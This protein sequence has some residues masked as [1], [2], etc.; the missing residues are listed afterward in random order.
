M[1]Q[2]PWRIA[3]PGRH[4][5]WRLQE[6]R[7]H[8]YSMIVISALLFTTLT[9]AEK[10]T[11]NHYCLYGATI[12]G[13]F[14]L[15]TTTRAALDRWSAHSC[16]CSSSRGPGRSPGGPWQRRRHAPGTGG[17]AG[18]YVAFVRETQRERDRERERQRESLS[19]NARA[20]TT[21]IVSASW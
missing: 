19:S 2:A 5:P 17:A 9:A 4:T 13:P 21:G 6:A 10:A 18:R 15:S 1:R 11:C 12:T 8:W 7:P 20:V 14:Q 3:S 16:R